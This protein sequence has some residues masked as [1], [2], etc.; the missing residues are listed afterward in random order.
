MTKATENRVKDKLKNIMRDTGIPFN[1]L[2]LTLFLERFIVRIGKSK[3]AENLIFKGG[4][5]LNQYIDLK[6]QTIDMDFLLTKL[7]G[8]I[9]SIREMIEEV[10]QIEI[11]DDFEFSDV[12]VS[13]LSLEHKKYPG[14]RIDLQGYLGKINKKITIDIGIG[15]VVRA[16]SIEVELLKSNGPLFEESIQLNAYPPEYIFSEKLEAI[17]HLAES[18]GRMKDYFDCYHLIKSNV[19][20]PKTLK[21][22]ITDTTDNRGTKLALIT[23]NRDE[24]EKRWEIFSTK[25]KVEDLSL[26]ET[27]KEIN[28]LLKSLFDNL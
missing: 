17:L 3:H 23:H 7:K 26:D 12:K 15:D 2:L 28:T 25:N 19:L 27:I 18:N 4:M 20:T 8:N 5:C 9:D 21:K 22:A 24:L 14:Y 6:R 11:N 13:E 16:N 1:N 10:T